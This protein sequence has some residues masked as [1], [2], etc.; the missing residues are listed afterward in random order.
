MKF[1]IK[2]INKKNLL[3]AGIGNTLKGDD[4]AGCEVIKRLKKKR[5]KISFSLLDAGS[6]PENYT[7]IIKDFKPETIIFI[8]AVVMSELPGTIKIIEENEIYSGYF[9]THN[10]PLNMFIDY[11]KRE[12]KAK[13]VF[14]GIQPKSIKFGEGFSAEVQK[15][16]EELV[17]I[18]CTSWE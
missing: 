15:S 18:L 1:D 10:M 14:I 2:K 17:K 4:G 6:A 16:V 12:T 8:D 9:T 5:L 13:I 11:V 7:K 3:I